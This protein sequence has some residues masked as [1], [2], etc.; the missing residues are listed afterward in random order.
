MAPQNA[1]GNPFSADSLAGFMLLSVDKSKEQQIQDE[2]DLIA[3]AAH[4]G[5]IGVGFRLLSIGEG[6]NKSE[7]RS[8]ADDPKPLPSTWNQNDNSYTFTY[9][10]T[11]SSMQFL[12]KINRMLRKAIVSGMGDGDDKH[13]SFDLT[14]LEF[15]RPSNTYP[16]RI[17]TENTISDRLEGDIEDAKHRLLNDFFQSPGRLSDI[18]VLLKQRIVQKLAPGISKPGYEETADANNTSSE[19][20]AADGVRPGASREGQPRQPLPHGDLPEPARPN[21]YGIHDPLAMPPRPRRDPGELYPPGFTDEYE[22]NR[23]PGRGGPGFRGPPMGIGERDLYPP[24]L[25]PHDPMRPFLGPGHPATG[26]IG[27]GG[28]HPTFDDPM[29]GGLGG[30]GGGFDPQAPPGARFDPVN[31][32]QRGPPRGSGGRG[33]FGGAPPNPFGGFGSGDFI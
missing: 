32:G 11:Q 16:L 12:V 18:G 15:V 14:P 4:A 29:F 19:D 13:Y 6:R 1:A 5:M 31:P 21:P 17:A 7:C 22:V 10:H 26:G 3:L 20:R 33:G 28:M 24:G 30:E 8:E 23:P 2:F 25:G 27:G 9:A